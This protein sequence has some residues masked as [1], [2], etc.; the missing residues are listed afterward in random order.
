MILVFKFINRI[1]NNFKIIIIFKN[2]IQL[3]IILFFVE[4][5]KQFQKKNIIF[6][7]EKIILDFY[8]FSCKMMKRNEE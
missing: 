8:V 7:T 6:L 5:I 2:I 3:I 4:F 1:N